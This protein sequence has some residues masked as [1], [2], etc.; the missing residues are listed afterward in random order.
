MRTNLFKNIDYYWYEMKSWHNW[1]SDAEEN[2]N[3][4]QRRSWAF[5]AWRELII[6]AMDCR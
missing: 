1:L 2:S 4:K 6:F 3:E 5:A